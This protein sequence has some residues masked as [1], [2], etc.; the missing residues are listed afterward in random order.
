[1]ILNLFQ[2]LNSLKETYDVA[3][4]FNFSTT[5]LPTDNQQPVNCGLM[6]L[7]IKGHVDLDLRKMLTEFV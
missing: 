1:M 3:E 4:K 5:F 2:L 7:N 6:D